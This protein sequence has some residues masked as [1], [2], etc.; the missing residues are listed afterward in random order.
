MKYRLYEL[1]LTNA[2]RTLKQQP[3]IPTK[4]EH[5]QQRKANFDVWEIT[6]AARLVEKID[7]G[8]KHSPHNFE[9]RSEQIWKHATIA[10]SM[11]E[12]LLDDP[13]SNQH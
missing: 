2:W 5:I 8:E 11:E 4:L 1:L 7:I 13:S 10:E 3:T 6:N 12:Q 9:T